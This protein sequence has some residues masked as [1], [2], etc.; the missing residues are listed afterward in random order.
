MVEYVNQLPCLPTSSLGL[1]LMTRGSFSTVHLTGA[2]PMST[3]CCQFWIFLGEIRISKVKR[4]KASMADFNRTNIH[5]NITPEQFSGRGGGRRF[6]RGRG[7][8]WRV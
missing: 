4:E 7:R 1:T 8:K 3:V 2:H 6:W 5:T